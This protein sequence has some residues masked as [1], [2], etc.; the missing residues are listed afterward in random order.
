MLCQ[1]ES[2]VV[3]AA[4]KQDL[5]NLMT[6]NVVCGGNIAVTFSADPFVTLDRFEVPPRTIMTR[7]R[8]STGS[9]KENTTATTTPEG[10]ATPGVRLG[11]MLGV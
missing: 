2:L 4:V 8:S 11:S 5:A 10:Q 1:F 7:S 3:F 9:P 6:D